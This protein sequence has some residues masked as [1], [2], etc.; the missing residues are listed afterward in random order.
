MILILLIVIAQ[1]QPAAELKD[2]KVE[3]YLD[4]DMTVTVKEFYTLL[5]YDI[6]GYINISKSGVLSNWKEF[7]NDT[8]FGYHISGEG[9]VRENINIEASQISLRNYNSGFAY[10]TIQY[11]IRPGNKGLFQILNRTSRLEIIAMDPNYLAFTRTSNNN[12][13]LTGNE[14]LLFRFHP[15]YQ[16]IKISPTPNIEGDAYVWTNTA[17]NDPI[18]LLK[19]RVSYDVLIIQG[20]KNIYNNISKFLTIP[21]VWIYLSLFIIFFIFTKKVLYYD[22][23]GRI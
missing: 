13:L 21:E 14:R 5:V 18:I 7:I 9:L 19:K 10:L 12:I 17:L 23:Q 8:K 4:N 16:V 20:S 11:T 15:S 1:S 3:I 6:D 22:K 2:I